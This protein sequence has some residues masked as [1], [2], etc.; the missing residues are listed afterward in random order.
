MVNAPCGVIVLVNTGDFRTYHKPNFG[1]SFFFK[2]RVGKPEF[3]LQT[4]EPTTYWLKLFLKLRKPLGVRKIT[5]GDKP[6][7]FNT[8]PQIYILRS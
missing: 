4:I 7:T 8:A 5:S 6:Q 3:G 1:R 2:P